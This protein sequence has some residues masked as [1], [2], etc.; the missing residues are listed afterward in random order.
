MK[1]PDFEY[2]RPDSIE[3]AADALAAAAGDAKVLAGGQSLVP[4]LNFR[5]VSPGLLVD[6]GRIPGLS[7]IEWSDGSLT[8]GA[9]TP[10]RR[11]EREP[12]IR[13]TI[14]LLSTASA[15]VGHPQ[16]RNRGTI[17]GS[18]AHADPAAE[19]PAIFVLLDGEVT[20]RS[21]RG[22]RTIKA[23]DLFEG[24]LTTSL[25]EDEILTSIR[26][27]VPSAGTRW[28]FREFAHRRGDF[29]LAGAAVTLAFD[30]SGAITEARIVAFGTPDRPLR[31]V[32]AEA[33]LNG[34]RP[35]AAA[36]EEA[37]DTAA[38]AASADDARPDAEYRRAL[39]RTVTRRA[40]TDAMGQ[41]VARQEVA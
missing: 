33:V 8:L 15:W 41:D 37:A 25:G 9:M 6:I 2:L 18:L 20:A 10:T 12:A 26:V 14:P 40:L 29:A 34:Q 39:M 24:F 22:S 32:E 38:A 7:N 28:G 5:F 4:L 30:G 1:P 27:P 31:M 35:T 21:A 23:S 36:L 19:L 3:A 16:I 11:C 13:A 17:G